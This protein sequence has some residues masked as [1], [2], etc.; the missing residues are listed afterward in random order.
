MQPV[1]SRTR[2]KLRSCLTA[3]F[4]FV[5]LTA[6]NGCHAQPS[7]P[8]WDAYTSRFLDAQGRVIDHGAQDRTTTEGEAYAMFFALVANDPGRFDKLVDWTEANL[9]DGDLTL[10][11]PAWSWGKASDGSWHVLDANP[12]ADADLWMA[13][14]LEEAGRLWHIDRYEK[15]GSLMAERVAQSEV[16]LVPS[17]GT[18]MIPGAEGFHPDPHTWYL[19]PS[20]LPPSLLAYFAHVQPM[21][22]WREV[23]GSL[24]AVASTPSGFAMDWVRAGDDGITPSATPSAEQTARVDGKTCASAMGSYD[25][26]RVYLWMGLADPKTPGVRDALTGVGGMAAYLQTHMVPPL[27]V[28]ANG[29]VSNPN[30]PPG[31]SAAVI[32]YLHALGLKKAEQAQMDRLAA[33]KDLKTG[34]FGRDGEYY[35]QNLAMFESGWAEQRFRFE[36]DGRLHVKWK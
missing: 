31:F 22:P 26:I 4:L 14:D 18:T 34:L 24:P 17:V 28:S 33:T 10:H 8:L 16:V 3:A 11:L 36:A 32:P 19:N 21:S 5:L 9:A 12:A 30:G 23:L 35:D 1:P 25:A 6:G 2:G 13:Y 27:Q 7:W 20:Y 15:L 29:T